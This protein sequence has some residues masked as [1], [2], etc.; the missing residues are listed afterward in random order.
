MLEESEWPVLGDD[1]AAASLALE[2]MQTRARCHHDRWMAVRCPECA[3]EVA[4]SMGLV[5]RNR[6]PEG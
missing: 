3:V 5:A 1:W 4:A 6:A 2:L